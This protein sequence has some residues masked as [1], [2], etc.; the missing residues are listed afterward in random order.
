[1]NNS[2]IRVLLY[3]VFALAGFWIVSLFMIQVVDVMNFSSIA[4]KQYVPVREIIQ[5]LRGSIFDRNG[6]LLVSTQRLYSLDIDR[7]AIKEYAKHHSTETVKIKDSDVI[8]DV[9]DIISINSTLSKDEVLRKLASNPLARCVLIDD[10]INESS[11]QAIRSEFSKKRYRFHI[12]NFR[13]FQRVYQKGSLASRLIGAAMGDVDNLANTSNRENMLYDLKGICGLEKS[14]D[15]VLRGKH[16][17]R[18]MMYAANSKESIPY[19]GL[20]EEPAVNGKDIYLT[21]DSDI[22]EI[23]QGV[24]EEGLAKTSSKNAVGI[25]M[26][27]KT[28]EIYAMSSVNCN[29]KDRNINELRTMP[30]LAVSFLYEPGSTMKPVTAAAALQY[31]TISLNDTI[32]C[33]VRKETFGSGTHKKTRIIDDDDHSFHDLSLKDIIAFS[34]NPGISRVSDRIDDLKLYN[35]LRDFGF[36]RKTGTDFAEEANGIIRSIDKWT[37]YSKHSLSFGHEISV[38]PLQ[39][40]SAYV[41]IANDAKPLRPYIVNEIR[42]EKGI[43]KKGM[44][45]EG[46]RILKKEVAKDVQSALKAVVEYGTGSR[47]NLEYLNLAGKTGTAEKVDPVTRKYMNKYFASFC[48]YFPADDPE[49]MIMVMYDEASYRYR[50]GALSAGVSVNKIARGML[51]LPGYKLTEKKV[52]KDLV[53]KQVPNLKH[54]TPENAM[55]ILEEKNIQSELKL[56]NKDGVVVD[57][58]PEPGNGIGPGQKVILIVDVASETE[59]KEKEKISPEMPDLTGMSLRKAVKTAQNMNFTLSIDGTGTVFQQSVEPGEKMKPGLICKVQ[60]R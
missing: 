7:T 29:D 54:Q 57:Q 46:D 11:I 15:E 10:S 32:N 21:I 41:T 27:T 25:V 1:M 55:R 33:R 13:A 4:D 5:P 53:V 30:N 6:E 37:L 19:K 2:R 20:K 9:A 59:D 31:N 40:A 49:F 58:V 24:L 43:V 28:G 48:G 52:F 39:I 12:I 38:T 36:G 51:S 50:T 45:R 3:V 47:L 42:D 18:D 23:V 26:S 14:F 56:L 16:G 8:N 22:Q 34:S 60:L 35:T 44:P 17:W